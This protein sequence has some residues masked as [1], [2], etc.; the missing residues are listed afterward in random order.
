MDVWTWNVYLIWLIHFEFCRNFPTYC[1]LA[2][3]IEQLKSDFF[4]KMEDNWWKYLSQLFLTSYFFLVCL[5]GNL[6]SVPYI[7]PPWLYPLFVATLIPNV[8]STEQAREPSCQHSYNQSIIL[9][10]CFYLH[11]KWNFLLYLAYDS[12]FMI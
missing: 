7:I 4:L 10:W 9:R 11:I 12:G 1:N 8:W 3:K 6:L 2:D 5:N